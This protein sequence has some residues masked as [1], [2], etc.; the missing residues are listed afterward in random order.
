MHI[1]LLTL[2]AIREH[3]PK[4]T[5]KLLLASFHNDMKLY[6]RFPCSEEGE[7]A[8]TGARVEVPGGSR[9]GGGGYLSTFTYKRLVVLAPRHPA[10][11]VDVF[12]LRLQMNAEVYFLMREDFECTVSTDS[13]MWGILRFQ[14][15]GQ[16]F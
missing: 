4:M 16:E 7:P 15:T 14:V 13:Q 10:V 8:M 1:V 6:S 5:R 3:H 9:V 11:S 12:I 2:P